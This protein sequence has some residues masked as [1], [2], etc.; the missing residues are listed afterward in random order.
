MNELQWMVEMVGFY[1]DIAKL[2]LEFGSS[3]L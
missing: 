2:T 3:D 1:Y